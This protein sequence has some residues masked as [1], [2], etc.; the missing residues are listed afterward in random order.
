MLTEQEVDDL[1]RGSQPRYDALMR[2]LQALGSAVVAF[3]GGCDSALVAKLAFDAL[4]ERAVALTALSPSVPEEEVS[5]AREFT[6]ALGIRHVFVDSQELTDARYAQNPIDRCYFCKTEL[7]DLCQREAEA[8]GLQA[9]LDGFNADDFK[10][11]RPGHRA[12]SE[13]QVLSP[14]ARHGLT[15]LEVRA[16][17]RRLGLSTWDKPQAACLASRLPYGTPV[18]AQR[19]NQVGSAERAL[20][21]L[22]LAV[23]RVRYHGDV[24]RLEVGAD[25]LPRLLD[26]AFRHQVDQ[27]V[28]GCGFTYVAV[29]LEPFRSGRLND[30]LRKGS[31]A[32]P[33]LSSSV[34][35][36]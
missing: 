21:G 29:D 17:S 28:K 4:G 20:K 9:V 31:L 34:V 36:S 10:D 11:H 18:T 32:L 24:A 14:L 5:A 7:Y 12:A 27:A 6:R 30:A 8:L 13:H 25:E 2:E 35:S 22:G 15:K 19:L 23:F 26:P 33:V 3:S 1:C 16:W